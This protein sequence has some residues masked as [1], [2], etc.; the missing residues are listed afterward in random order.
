MA[1]RRESGRNSL[2][3]GT[4]T[5]SAKGTLGANLPAAGIIGRRRRELPPGRAVLGGLLIAAAAVVVFAGA[6]S[7]TRSHSAGYVVAARPL[8]A[9]TIIAP[10]DTAIEHFSMPA[11][12]R[13]QV[14]A[15]TGVVMGRTLAVAAT[16]GELLQVTMLAPAGGPAALRPVSIAVDPTSLAGLSAG[17]P[18][19]VLATPAAGTGGTVDPGSTGS[20]GGPG[21]SG[22]SGGSGSSGGSASPAASGSVAVVLRGAALLSITRPGSTLAP[23]SGSGTVVT[24]GVSSL[25]E[26]ELV[27]QAAHTDTIT[28]IRADPSDGTGA[29]PAPPG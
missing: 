5:D 21:G 23:V 16:P 24:L 4:S 3:V 26:V 8:A 17:D 29:G 9:G 20:S 12:A 25:S 19:D 22:G 14:F 15:D 18:V 11:E 7:A 6:L 27:V 2:L 28:L 10:G 13:G 1:W